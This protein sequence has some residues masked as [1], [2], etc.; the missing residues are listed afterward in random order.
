MNTS[1]C[2]SYRDE[3]LQHFL[4]GTALSETARE[5]YLS[6][7]GCIAAVTARLNQIVSGP[8]DQPRSNGQ[9]GKSEVDSAVLPEQAREALGHGRA[10]VAREFGWTTQEKAETA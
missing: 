3:I 1:A 4:A 6:C 5:H 7:V 2:F 10:V 9:T 8:V